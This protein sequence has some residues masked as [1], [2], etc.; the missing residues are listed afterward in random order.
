[1]IRTKIVAT[2]G[3]ACSDVA[4]LTK[5]FEAGVDVCRVNFSHG[6]LDTALATLRNIR[7][8]AT[9]T[10]LPVAVLGDL[11]GPKIRLGKVIDANGAGGM[12]I[13]VGDTLT[14][15][16]LPIVGVEGRVSSTYPGLIDDVKIGDRVLIED[17]LIRFV[18]TEK[19]DDQIICSCTSGGILKSSKGINLPNSAV[20]LPSITE[21]DWECVDWA[22]ENHLDYLA[23]S[24]VRKAQD[25][26]DLRQYLHDKVSDIHL[27]AKIEKAEAIVEIDAIIEA[28]DGLMV[29]R[30]DLGVEM[31]VARVPIIQKDLI[32]RCQAAG[33]PVIVATQMLQSMIENSSPTRAEVSDVA[34]AIIDGTDAVM[35][36]GETSVGKFP[37]GSVLTMA[38][39]ASVTED[40]LA[41][42]FDEDS[43]S[44]PHVRTTLPSGAIA[45]GAADRPRTESEAGGGLDDDRR[46]RPRLL[47]TSLPG[48]AHRIVQRP[49]RAAPNGTAVWRDRPGN[50]GL[51]GDERSDPRHRCAGDRTQIR[52]AI[53]SGRHCR[54][55]VAG[56]ARNHERHD[57]SHRRSALDCDA[58]CAGAATVDQ[59]RA[60]VVI[61]LEEE[62]SPSPQSSPGIPGEG[63]TKRVPGRAAQRTAFNS[64]LHALIEFRLHKLRGPARLRRGFR[65]LPPLPVLR[66]R[67]GVR[68]IWSFESRWFRT[69]IVCDR[70]M[71]HL[72]LR[73]GHA[74][75]LVV[76]FL[77]AGTGCESTNAPP[78]TRPATDV[79]YHEGQSNFWY[80]KPGRANATCGNY[81]AL[82]QNSMRV[83]HAD[84]FFIDREEYRDGLLTT[85]PLISAQIFEPWRNDVG[86]LRGAV[87]STIATVRRTIHFDIR[88]LP[89][90][91]YSVVPKVLIERHSLAER[92]ITSVTEYLDVFAVDRP[93]DQPYTEEGVAL[94]PDYWYAVGRDYAL[95]KKLVRQLENSLAGLACD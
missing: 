92:R 91:R 69:P 34:N 41:A 28:S 56:D 5:L 83:A 87:Q 37:I 44:P 89:D 84:G 58:Q 35:L 76:L 77:L 71:R 11:C 55:M 22:V 65:T 31:D 78:T 29:A 86:D 67:A 13:K 2:M 47:E 93:L 20:N 79:D 59:G 51:P 38:H 30:G 7:E 39:V 26:I 64:L 54:R 19:T 53:G 6:S 63:V 66:E 18:C 43:P 46:D 14:I 75:A 48:S 70:D 27:I 12:P 40:Y 10:G 88:K 8:A 62:K 1:M 32:R 9:A 21:R 52:R 49:A 60:G 3:P 16:R 74:C 23:L 42:R 45:R 57:D 15:V 50:A 68:V 80:A 72:V 82:W 36:S 33:K 94:V 81:D 85:K 24:F 25:L 73:V 95:E 90:G 61:L 17:G 4:S